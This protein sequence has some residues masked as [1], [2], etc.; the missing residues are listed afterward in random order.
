MPSRAMGLWGI[1]CFLIFLEQSWGQEQIY[2]VSAPKIFRV[3]APENILIQGHEYTEAFEATISVKSYPDKEWSY[4]SGRVHLSPENKFQNST[5]LTIQP[6][7]LP[8]GPNAVSY[9]YLEVVSRHFSELKQVPITYDNGFLFIDTGKS[10]YTPQESVKVKVYSFNDDLKPAKRETVLTFIDPEGSEVDIAA[11]DYRG[12]TSLFDFRIPSHPKY[13]VWTIIAKY[14]EDFSTTGTSSFEIK[15]YVLPHFSVSIEPESNFIGYKNF[16][17]FEITIKASD[18]YNKAVTEAEVHVFFGIKE[19]EKDDQKEMMQKAKQDTKL[20]NGVAHVTFDSETAVKELSY[21]SL[22]DVNNKY[23]YIAVTVRESSGGFSEEA[24]VSGIKYILSPYTLSLV[25]TPL[26]LKP[27]IP[28][29]VKVQVKD[30]L[31]KSVG[32]V[33]V[34]LNAQTVDVNQGTSD[35]ELQKSVTRLSD[36]VASFVVNPPPGVTVLEFSVKTDAPD[37]PEE[38]Q[39]GKHYQAVAYSSPSHSYLYIHWV[40]DS[41]DMLVGEHLNITITAKSQYIHKITSYNY[42]I[43]SK[44][45]IV[46]FGTREKLPDSSSQSINIPVTWNMVPSALLLV[47]YIIPGEQTAEL[48]SDSILLNVEE[49]SYNLLQVFQALEKS[50]LDYGAGGGRDNADVFHLAG[51]I[52]L[53]NANADDSPENAAKYK[54]PV[55]KKCCFDGAIRND[56]ESCEERVVRVT[57][58]PRSMG[59]FRILCFLIFLGKNL[60]QE[61]TYVISAPKVFRVGAS[62]N[63]VIQVYG[64]TEAF[65]AT[66]S[67]KSYPDKK[68]SYSSGYVNLSPENKFQNSAFLT[69]QPKQLS[70]GQNPVSYVYLEVVSKHFSKSKK[71]PITDDNGFLFVHTDKPVYTPHQ[72]VKVRVYS[73]TDDLQPAKRVTVLTFIDPEGA[74]VDLLE[75]NDYTG[76]I[77]FPDFKIPSNPKYGIWTINAKYK[78]DFSTTGTT[79]FEIKEYVLPRFSV[80]IEPES[81]FISYKNFKNFGITITARY[82]YNKVVTDAEVY[83]FYGIREDIKDDQKEMMP[84]AMRS[85]LLV[86]GVAH[87]TFDSEAA[88]KELSYGSLEDLNDKYLYIAVT[89]VEL[90]GGFTEEAEI[91]GIKYAL[92]PYTL[93]LVATPLY[94]KP[95]IPYSVKVQVKDSL[96]Q[97]VG[98]IPV[99]LNAQT[100]DINQETSHLEPKK[101]VTSLTD[102]VAS[103]VVNL[104]SGVTA[105]EFDVQTDAPDLPEENQA[106]KEYRAVAYSSLSQSYLYIDWTENYKPLLVGEHLNIIITPKSPYI[107]KIMHYNYLILSKGKIVHFGTR[108][109]LPDSSYQSINVPVTQSMVPSARLLVYYIVTGEQTAELVSDSVW[110]NIEEKCGNQLQVHLSPDTDTYSPGQTVSLNMATESNSW[111]ALAAVDSAVYGVQGRAKRPMQR[112][113]QALEKSDLGCGAGGGR[114]NAD[115]FH[116]AGLTF[117]TNANADDSPQ[118]DKPCKEIL[119]P[120]RNLQ[121]TVQEQAAK[122]R[123]P[124]PKKCCYDGARHSD[125]ETC[126]Q[127]VARVTLGPYCIRAFNECCILATKFRDEN[128]LKHI[129]LGRQHIRY[130]SPAIKAEVRSYFPESWL[131]EVHHVPK[132]NQ[133]RL[134]LPDSLTTWEIQGVGISNSG[135]CVADAVKAKVFK[136][137]FLEVN[138]PYSVVR[139]EQIQLKGTVYNYR[140]SGMMFCVKM[141][142]VEGIC[143]SENPAIT[144][145]G[146]KSSKCVRQ[147][148][149]GSSSHLV[150]FTLLPLEIGLHTINF[151]LETSFGRE[152]LVKTLRVVPEGVKKE[153]YAGVTLDPRGIYG[154]ISRR[155][156][157]PYRVPLDMV[158]KTNV[159]RILSVKGLLIGEMLSTVLSQEGIDTLLHL[160]KG[161]AEAELM[162]I[163]PLF[164]VFHYLEAGNHW[165]IFHPNSLTKTQYLKKKIKEGMVSIMSYRNLDYSYS[166]WKGG[167]SSTW[168]TAFALRV[169]GQVNKYVEQNQNSICNSLLWLVDNCQLENG[170]FKEHSHYHPIKLQGTLP[171]EAKQN[172]LYLTAF[173]VIG[174]RKAFDVCPL[175]KISTALTKADNFLLENVL[176][177]QNTFTLA[178]VAYA[179][180]LGDKMHPRFHSIV[181]ALKKEASV[182][183]NP[184]IYRFWKDNVHEAGSSAPSAGTAG[185]VETTAYALLTSLNLKEINYVNPIIKWLA[186]EQRYGGGF[187][188]TQDT[189][190][191]IEGLTEYSLLI[192]QL[193]LNMDINV[194]YKH[195]GDL[196]H[197]KVTDK[198]FL[199][200]PIEVPLNDDLV[201][202]TGHSNG[203]ATVHVKTIVHKISTSEEVCNFYLKIDTQ[204]IE[205]PSSIQSDSGYKRIVAC[206]SYKPSREESSSGSSHA[207]MDISLPTGINANQEDL[208][209]ASLVEGVDQLLTDYQIQEGHVILQLNSIPTNDFL[210]VRFRIFEL[211]QVGY[212]NPATFTVY[213]Y[214]RPDKQCTMFYSTSGTKLEKVCE[215]ATC[216]CVEADCGQMEK[217]LDLTISAGTRKETACKPEIAYAYKVSI[218]SITEENVFVKYTATLLDVYKAGEAV[219]EKGSEITFIKKTTCTN[220]ALVK[221]RQYLIMGKEALQ[222][223]HNFS[224]RYIYPLDSSTWIEYWPTDTT[225]ASCGA[226]LANLDEFAED[227]FLNGCENI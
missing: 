91:P 132:R 224:F 215:E 60:G 121:E 81:N 124:R 134:A 86:N 178:I 161:S 182:K 99:I 108:E 142:T 84:E 44:G 56:Y 157:F 27:G 201:I 55:P 52:F 35:L 186:E 30:A 42:L 13:G 144:H 5:L 66:I 212:L 176:P 78:E 75:E 151:S 65:E 6:K 128:P 219:A 125:Y 48:V 119:R 2:V 15:E 130:L 203:L 118:N 115:V 196:Y 22:E 154:A 148:V 50:G 110:L 102:G 202:S 123:H 169:L 120:R 38:N 33:P 214:H 111:V 49:E 53:T 153:S 149:E 98:E 31:E 58:G 135:I 141:S 104:P 194:S 166:M 171:V 47:Y 109:K 195:K 93:N 216:K 106:R 62:E 185:M 117:L 200:R 205:A 8:R 188:S 192:K 77:S 92:S 54:H 88:V 209:A 83:I 94:L 90:T 227:I 113:F 45:K 18:S 95:G 175:M 133:L 63:I 26:I 70:G 173:T 136:D 10:V 221:G 163:V 158:P 150:T 39:A 101:S 11:N 190:N 7:Q 28:Y 206:A 23:L 187:Y 69:I 131:W 207:V 72:S 218:T 3:G 116:L 197:Y 64:Y 105:L 179:L 143:T 170:S 17:N 87:D 162:S 129:Q 152:I 80:S 180:S 160:P 51:L 16:K 165:N 82:F 57:I 167:D 222:I 177:S 191:A 137:V 226:F 155:R 1:L 25:A 208:R 100:V 20:T 43:L 61:Q 14:K 183:G 198:N 220:A 9:V 138:I 71:V 41:K 68:F 73:L 24:E 12:G 122:Y 146:T 107:D 223:K 85:V 74:E 19:E 76:I 156:E 37:L 67:I 217:E 181:T 126:Q 145:Q 147:R 36:G 204:D 193:R 32:G 96:D 59:P 159:K 140:T 112:V 184:P 213:E 79:Y 172:A 29:S 168:L 46:Q 199:G 40:G 21:N 114:N 225:C 164:Y 127:R 103:F 189:I 139:G 210:C 174:I 89:V 211:F 34:I 4:S 97:S